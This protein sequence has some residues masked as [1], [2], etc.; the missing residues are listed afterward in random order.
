MPKTHRQERLD[1]DAFGTKPNTPSAL[2][3][4]IAEG[5]TGQDTA[6]KAFKALKPTS[7]KGDIISDD[8][9]DQRVLPA[10]T[11]THVLTAD[12]GELSGLKWAAA[13][14]SGSVVLGHSGAGSTI[15][16]G[17]T[18]YVGLGSGGV[19][20]TE[21]D[22][23]FYSPVAGT[24]QNLRTYVSANGSNNGGNTITV[25]VNG[26]SSSVV[27]TYGS[28]GTGLQSDTS[29]TVSVSAGDRV[30]IEVVN[31]GSGGGTKNLVVESISFEVA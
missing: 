11:D 21:A 7:A 12:S 8:G 19:Q 30:S 9:T 17:S 25:R 10:G 31:T 6:A 24:I 26:V 15:S 20:G 2:P 4:P 28:G 1:A 22:A 13:P 5:G 3:V 14:G 27:T 29:N 23:E 16:K 18:D